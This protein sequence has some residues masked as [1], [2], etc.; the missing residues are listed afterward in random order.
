MDKEASIEMTHTA[1]FDK[2]KDTAEIV[3]STLA[4]IKGGASVKSQIYLGNDIFLTIKSNYPA[5]P[6]DIRKIRENDD[7][8]FPTREG[9]CL[10]GSEWAVFYSLRQVIHQRL[11]GAERDVNKI[12]NHMKERIQ[13]RQNIHVQPKA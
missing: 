1:S 4:I 9:Q 2:L 13:S 10:T 6:V 8:I 5:T 11:L 3:N 7:R 12:L